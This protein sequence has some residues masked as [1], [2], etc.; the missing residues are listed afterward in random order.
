MSCLVFLYLAV[1]DVVCIVY[2]VG[3]TSLMNRFVSNKFSLKYKATIGVDF[4]QKDINFDD[5]NVT[6]Q[7]WDTCGQERF[8]NLDSA[9]YRGAN[10]AVIVFDVSN[11]KS[12]D[13]L[14]AWIENFLENASPKNVNE[15]PFLI[16]G[17]KCDLAEEQ[18]AVTKS[19][20]KQW[21]SS[22]NFNHGKGLPFYLTSAKED[23][24]VENG[25]RKIG[26]LATVYAKEH[27]SQVQMK[28]VTLDGD[29]RGRR[30]RSV[31]GKDCKCQLL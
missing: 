6:L 23:T 10:A 25:F 29:S 19:G 17:N 28:A 12:F 5:K 7:I 24:N 4:L 21:C 15:F 1:I 9:F 22:Q 18:W 14:D 16:L 8:A 13:A 11:Q 26:K 30:N 20:V 27:K 3:K 31:A 2:S